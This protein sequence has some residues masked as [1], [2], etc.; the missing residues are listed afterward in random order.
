[1]LR[2]GKFWFRN[3]EVVLLS[4]S[5]RDTEA[6]ASALE[7]AQERGNETFVVNDLAVVSLKHPAQLVAVLVTS[8]P[9]LVEGVFHWP[10][11]GSGTIKD[12]RDIAQRASE[13]Y[14]PLNQPPGMLLVASHSYYNDQW[15]SE[16]G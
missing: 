1:M 13:G 16:Y 10:C 2:L 3:D 15:W 8:V 12:L 6:L 5:P 14:F 9:I 4:G 7:D 11:H